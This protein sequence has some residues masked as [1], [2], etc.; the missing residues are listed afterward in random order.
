MGKEAK[1]RE[2]E[3]LG[4]AEDFYVYRVRDSLTYCDKGG[5]RERSIAVSPQ[6]R[7]HWKKEAKKRQRLDSAGITG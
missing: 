3:M 6:H 2:A 1:L 4:G 7:E 5:H